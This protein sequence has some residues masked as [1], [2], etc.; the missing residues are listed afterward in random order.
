MCWRILSLDAETQS[1]PVGPGGGVKVCLGPGLTRLTALISL[2]D[3]KGAS[4]NHIL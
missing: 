3:N 1:G 2:S 4:F